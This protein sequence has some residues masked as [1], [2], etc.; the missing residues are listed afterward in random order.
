MMARE[1]LGGASSAPCVSILLSLH[2]LRARPAP[3]P[4]FLVCCRVDCSVH[5]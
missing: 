4:E 1:E 2:S 3:A 5:S